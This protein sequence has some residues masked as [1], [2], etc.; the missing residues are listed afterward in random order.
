MSVVLPPGMKVLGNGSLIQGGDMKRRRLPSSK[1]LSTQTIEK[2]KARILSRLK[3][4][5]AWNAKYHLLVKFKKQHGHT[6]VPA[7]MDSLSYP[8]LGAWVIEQRGALRADKQAIDEALASDGLT[9]ETAGTVPL[10]SPTQK[11]AAL[12]TRGKKITKD[13]KTKMAIKITL[14][15]YKAEKDSKFDF[16][17]AAKADCA[18]DPVLPGIPN[19]EKQNGAAAAGRRIARLD[20][21]SFDWGETRQSRWNRMFSLLKKYK[22]E[23]GDVLVPSNKDTE[24]YPRLGV[25]VV[26]QRRAYRETMQSKRIADGTALS[27]TNAPQKRQTVCRT[28]SQIQEKKK[29]QVGEEGKLNSMYYCYL[30]VN[31]P[32]I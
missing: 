21:I 24:E 16:L 32:T 4:W 11:S 23:H 29:L 20:M 5:Q 8:K 3:R 12:H 2:T 13:V 9:V 25:W 14:A 28:I 7:N 17:E 27:N 19:V 30:I 1:P 18:H 22:D 6:S 26:A 15:A 10:H 31:Y